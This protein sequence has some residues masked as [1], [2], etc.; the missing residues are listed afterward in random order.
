MKLKKLEVSGFKSFPEKTQIDFTQGISAIVGPNGCGKSNV[1]DA[2]RWAMGEQSVK[3]LRGK[4]MEDIIFSGA[5]GKPPLNMAEVTLTLLNNGTA[6]EELKDF[7]EIQVT[8]RIYRSGESAY[9]MNKRPCR[10]KDI[11]NLFLG[12]GMG[13][14]SYAIIQQGNIGAI[15]DAGPE[16]RRIFIEEAAG[17][18]RY[19]TRKKEALQK[20][21]ATDQNLLRLNDVISEVHRQMAG[22]NRQAKKAERFQKIQHKIQKLDILVNLEKYGRLSAEMEETGGLLK[23]LKE[24]D[25]GQTVKLNQL[26]AAVEKIK[27]ERSRKNNEISRQKSTHFD[28]QRRID[29]LEN[30]LMHLRRQLL[31]RQKEIEDLESA[32]K[33]LDGKNRH[34]ADEVTQTESEI[35]RLEENVAEVKEKLSKERNSLREMKDQMA[36]LHEKLEKYKKQLME[37]VAQEARINNIYQTA[38]QNMESIERRLKR[39]DEEVIAAGKKVEQYAGDESVAR[40]RLAVCRENIAVLQSAIN[41][42][43]EEVEF[44]ARSLGEQVKLAQ[45]LEFSR[46]ETRSKYNALKKMSENFEWYKDGVKAIL[47]RAASHYDKTENAIFGIVADVVTPD[48]GYEAAVEAVLGE[49][50]QYVLVKDQNIGESSINY[51][52]AN[53]SGRSGFI[54][55]ESLRN[56]P[57]SSSVPDFSSPLLSY[58]H[59]QKGFE[60]AMQALLGNVMVV[61]DLKVAITL[62]NQNGGVRRIVTTDGQVISE[63][64]IMA[65]GSKDR[66]SGILEKKRE[67]LELENHLG[68]VEEKLV[69][70]KRSQEQMEIEVRQLETDLQ[71]QIQEKSHLSLEQMD[72]EKL[73]IKITE[74]LKSARRH[75]EIV[76]LEQDQLLGEQTDTD[77]EVVRYDKERSEIMQAVKTAQDQVSKTSMNIESLSSDLELR[78]EKVV[79]IQLNLTSL[80]ARLENDQNSLRR[81]ND[82]KQEGIKRFEQIADDIFLKKQKQN[83]DQGR[84][85]NNEQ[86]L[87]E[88]YNKLSNLEQQL[89]N[90][91]SDFQTIDARLK[92]NNQTRTEIE[93][94]RKQILEKLRYLEIEHSQQEMR[95][96]QIVSRLEDRYNQK[97]QKLNVKYGE[98]LEKLDISAEEMEAALEKN[99]D[100][101]QKLGDVNMGAIKE[102]EQH[103]TRYNFL[104]KQRDDLQKAIE[105]LHKVIRKINRIT[106]DKFMSTFEAIN[107]KMETIFPRLFEGGSA[108]LV[109]TEPDKPLETG[110]EFMIHPPGKKLTRL[111]LLS[112]GEK[113]LSAIAFVF[114]IFL[115]KPASFCLLD[116]IDAPLDEANVYRFNNLLKLIG[117]SSQ[118]IMITHKKRTMEFSDTLL[119]V[120]MEKKGI[121][122]L[123]SVNLGVKFN[124]QCDRN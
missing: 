48:P 54:P 113:A 14:R 57:S 101:L 33:E 47:K 59:V 18:S 21:N 93:S 62:W 100:K 68:R 72:V 84:I 23:S 110:V 112:G 9:L 34:I 87:S 114:S 26:D 75:L 76:Q 78:N 1:I 38:T 65:G 13:A 106:Q 115:I 58:V 121:S 36:P 77:H 10:L 29:T 96:D 102:Y 8:R 103:E 98:M 11:H 61:S 109:L 90:N 79:D 99:R 81:L 71:Q 35:A 74:E 120:T 53:G 85:E 3:Q 31:Q 27:L 39:I 80:A 95:H 107:Q 119:G 63:Q 91:E 60:S 66:L 46:R 69:L 20:I 5:A 30:D 49:G 97:F 52:A 15:T 108:K 82:F 28:I 12:S 43:K 116:E 123:V 44:R 42:L 32:R 64:G 7:S 122:K 117:E 45:T 25:F 94:R 51:L 89:E 4:S 73:L 86:L 105:D 22:L 56:V 67:I 118:I 70:A 6:P 41:K 40:E 111:S 37:L 24:E 55:L 104:N 2:I 19:K 17:V 88:L 83:K 16:E 124:E 92:E 50:L